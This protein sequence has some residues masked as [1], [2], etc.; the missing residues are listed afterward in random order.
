MTKLPLQPTSSGNDSP[1]SDNSSGFVGY[2]IIKVYLR[3]R[4]HRQSSVDTIIIVD[5]VHQ[6]VLHAEAIALGRYTFNRF[7]TL[8]IASLNFRLLRPNPVLYTPSTSYDASD[9]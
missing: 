6:L 3:Y 4:D 5:R 7:R 2:I 1:N 9:S 8:A